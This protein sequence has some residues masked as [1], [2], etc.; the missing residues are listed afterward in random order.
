[1][2]QLK[3]P[4]HHCSHNKRSVSGLGD[5]WHSCFPYNTSAHETAVKQ[6]K[7]SWALAHVVEEEYYA[8]GGGNHTRACFNPESC[9][10]INGITIHNFKRLK[11]WQ[12]ACMYVWMH[13]CVCVNVCVRCTGCKLIPPTLAGFVVQRRGEE[14][15]EEEEGA[16]AGRKAGKR[17][18]GG[19]LWMLTS[20]VVITQL[21]R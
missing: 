20:P 15:E 16:E 7:K 10:T 17:G 4:S 21:R 3:N 6:E 5:Q 1:M 12:I 2:Q 11:P 19:R 18:K 14:E 9:H 13:L 8:W